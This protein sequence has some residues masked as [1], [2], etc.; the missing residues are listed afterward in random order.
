M[1]VARSSFYDTVDM[2]MVD[3]EALVAH[4]GDSGRVPSL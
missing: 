2:G 4:A 3:R 1:G